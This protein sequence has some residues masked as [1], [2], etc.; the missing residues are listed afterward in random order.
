[1]RLKKRRINYFDNQKAVLSL[2]SE[3]FSSAAIIG[4]ESDFP[5]IQLHGISKLS[6]NNDFVKMWYFVIGEKA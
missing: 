4:Q 2:K 1:M 5:K 6:Q 3:H